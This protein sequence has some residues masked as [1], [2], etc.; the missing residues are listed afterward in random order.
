MTSYA[1]LLSKT[2]YSLNLSSSENHLKEKRKESNESCESVPKRLRSGLITECA[3]GIVHRHMSAEDDQESTVLMARKRPRSYKLSR[4]RRLKQQSGSS[5]DL[6][7]NCEPFSELMN[8]TEYCSQSLH[9]SDLL[10]RGTFFIYWLF[11]Y[12]YDMFYVVLNCRKYPPPP[13]FPQ[14]SALR[15]YSGQTN[16]VLSIQVKSLATLPR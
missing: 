13:S 15:M 1:S 3:A 8:G 11:F 9:T 14:I 6:V 5:A 7:N 10:Q 12:T 16:T 4:T 2:E